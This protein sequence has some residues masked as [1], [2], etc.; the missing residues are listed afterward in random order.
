[1]NRGDKHGCRTWSIWAVTFHRASSHTAE[2]QESVPG[3]SCNQ[4][5]V[6][7][8]CLLFGKGFRMIGLSCCCC[9]C[10]WLFCTKPTGDR[11][12]KGCFLDSYW[13]SPSDHSIFTGAILEPELAPQDMQLLCF[14]IILAHHA[15]KYLIMRRCCTLQL[16]C[17][18]LFKYDHRHHYLRPFLTP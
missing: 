9:C 13:L 7:L 8:T 14:V 15:V 2:L 17:Q 6:W 3:K 10:C 11:I 4:V 18:L 5:Q 16:F 1:M 12:N